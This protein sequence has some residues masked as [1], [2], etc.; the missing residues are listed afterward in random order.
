MCW[1]G[2]ERD[3]IQVGYILYCLGSPIPQ[4]WVEAPTEFIKQT[5]EAEVTIDDDGRF[6]DLRTT[7]YNSSAV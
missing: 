7:E 4:G 3:S 2:G 1:G 6:R 5:I